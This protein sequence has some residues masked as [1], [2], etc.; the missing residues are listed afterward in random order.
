METFINNIKK[1]FSLYNKL[2]KY[3]LSDDDINIIKNIKLSEY[4]IQKNK[5]VRNL[6]YRDNNF[7]ILLLAW[8]K[9]STTPTHN[10]PENGCVLYLIDGKLKEKRISEY[11]S[12]DSIICKNKQSYIDDSIGKHKIEAMEVSYSLHIYSPPN[13]YS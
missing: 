8:D 4:K 10:H 13:F 3:T 6:L 1:Y 11:C 9:G 2:D 12:I 7:E 5:Y